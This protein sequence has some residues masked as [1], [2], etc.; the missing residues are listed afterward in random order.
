MQKRPPII[1][2]L[3]H[4]YHGKTTL[5][6]YVRKTNLAAREAGGI[7]QSIGAYEIEHHGTPMTF[8]DTP[9]HEA[10]SVMRAR[11]ARV[12]DIAVLVV[13][14]DDG[15]KPQTEDALRHIQAA[16][17]PYIVAV[18]KVDL[19]TANV[20]KTK[21]DL[22]KIGVYLEG[23]GGNVSYQLISAKRGDGIA[24]LLDLI[25]LA[26][27][28]E[29]LSADPKKPAEGVVLTSVSDPR[30][31]VVMGVVVKDGTLQKGDA[32]YTPSASGKVRM[33]W[34]SDG[35][36]TAAAGPGQPALVFGMSSLPQAGESWSTIEAPLAVEKEEG[37]QLLPPRKDAVNV[38]LKAGEAGS[39]EA[40]ES[41]VR[42][43]GK[44]D[45]S[46]LAARVGDIYESDVK[47]AT[48]SHAIIVGF[49][50]KTDRGALNL[51]DARHVTVL[52]APIIY[53]LG[54]L[55]E[56]YLA[57]LRRKEERVVIV[58]AIFGTK[59]GKQ[60]V[61]GDVKGFVRNQEAFTIMDGEREIGSGKIV[62]LQ[63]ER[64]DMEEV[65]EG[66][67]AGLMADTKE[68]IKVGHRLVFA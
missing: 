18:N 46:V 42:K 27:E 40:L 17:I 63:S 37:E 6:D 67:E 51:A 24:E 20:E 41:F 35:K 10:F 54:D 15:V 44:E 48:T 55:L 9:G 2:V 31:G 62:N 33:M 25:A 5:L 16:G 61:G 32:L 43:I 30:R 68:L 64:K 14:A 58:K 66:K 59:D 8:I 34:G 1:A 23:M 39:L 19:A 11:G 12:A 49:S 13:A 22:M 36:I 4:I 28:V 7:T 45:I 57:T 65:Q 56:E 53:K 26:A 60:I 47:D 29:E 3:G 21:Q 52:E 50:V 38:I